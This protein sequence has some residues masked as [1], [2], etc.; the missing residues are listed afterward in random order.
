MFLVLYASE[1]ILPSQ[2]REVGAE[3]SAGVTP[4]LQMKTLAKEEF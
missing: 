3:V 2:P 1:F 4:D